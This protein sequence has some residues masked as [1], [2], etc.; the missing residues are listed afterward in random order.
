MANPNLQ[1]GNLLALPSYT[2]KEWLAMT[3]VGN[4]GHAQSPVALLQV[5]SQERWWLCA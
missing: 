4:Q 5:T 2:D 3:L 1:W